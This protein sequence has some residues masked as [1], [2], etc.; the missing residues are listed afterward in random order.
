MIK[1]NH[2]ESFSHVLCKTTEKNTKELI[3]SKLSGV[4]PEDKDTL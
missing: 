4:N 2:T 1:N 3:K